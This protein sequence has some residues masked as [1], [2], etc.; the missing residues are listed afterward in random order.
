MICEV[1][2]KT[3]YSKTCCKQGHFICDACHMSQALKNTLYGCL[4]ENS[5]NPITIMQKLMKEPQV[6]MHGP[7]HHVLVGAALLTAYY[8]SGGSIK[9]EPT[10]KE[11][12][13]RGKNVPGGTCGYWG[14]CG[15]A[16][17]AGIFFSIITKTTPLSSQNWGLG[18]MLTSRVLGEIGKAGGPRCCKRASFLTISASICFVREN[19][20]IC[21]DSQDSISCTFW[22]GNNECLQYQC[23]FYHTDPAV[24]YNGN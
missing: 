2:G 21:M 20:G 1:C 12:V 15:A 19:L 24:I 8:N 16:I 10:L 13:L 6:C 17:S 9:L 22:R 5:R 7:E 14:C 3:F 4:S 23:P 11:M 18:S